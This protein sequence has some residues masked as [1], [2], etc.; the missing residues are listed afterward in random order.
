MVCYVFISPLS[1]TC[2]INRNT[3]IALVTE[4]MIKN[5]KINTP[6]SEM[7]VLFTSLSLM[8]EDLVPDN[9]PEWDV[10]LVMREIV[11]V[12]LQKKVHKNTHIWLRDLVAEHH[13]MFQTI[14]KQEE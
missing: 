6:A 12:V 10:Y 4:E 3:N 11:S 2:L 9:S 13:S 1:C 7:L 5:R 8:I 14:F